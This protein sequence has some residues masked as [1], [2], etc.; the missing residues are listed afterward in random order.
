MEWR[1]RLST[2][3]PNA[4][5]VCRWTFWKIGPYYDIQRMLVPSLP[6]NLRVQR[7]LHA[8][9]LLL[10]IWRHNCEHYTNVLVQM[11]LPNIVHN[12]IGRICTYLKY[13]TC[14]FYMYL[15]SI[16]EY[17]DLLAILICQ[18]HYFLCKHSRLSIFSLSTPT[19]P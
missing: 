6:Q 3:R 11:Y 2:Q 14:R 16:L 9:L 4:S 12:L 7:S 8:D 15:Y 18:L 5:P 17:K 1:V 19:F 10:D 13:N